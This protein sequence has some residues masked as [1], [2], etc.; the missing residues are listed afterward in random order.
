MAFRR[1][2]PNRIS[3][4]SSSDREL[5]LEQVN[6]ALRDELS[7]EVSI[8]KSNEKYIKDLER[9]YTRC[10]NE[11]Q[12]LNKELEQLENASN[13]EK[14]ELR[15]EISSLK[16][17]L[18]QAKKEVR[19][20]ISY[21]DNIEKQLQESE[22]RIQN[23]RHRFK[24][25]SSRR[26]S[27]SLYNSEEEDIDME[28]LDLFIQIE[29]GLTRIEN[30]LRGAGTPLNNPINIIN[31]IRGSLNTVRHN[32]QSAYQDIDGVIAQRDDSN[33]QIVQLQQDVNYY[34]QQN[35][36]LQN[37]TNQLIQV[38]DTLQ[39][40]VNRLTLERNNSQNNLALMTTAYN[41]ERTECRRWR[42]IAQ[43]FE[44]GMQMR[45]NNLLL[46]KF[47]LNF[48]LRRCQRHG[49]EL[50]QKYDMRGY[51]WHNVTLVL[52][53][54]FKLRHAFEIIFKAFIYRLEQE[55]Q[56]CRGDKGLLE[57]NRDRLF[58][59][60]YNKFKDRKASHIKWKNR[61]RN[62]QQL[63]LNLQAQI[64][65]LQN[66]Q[67]INLNMAAADRQHIYQTIQTSLAHIPSYIGQEP[68]DDYSVNIQNKSHSD[69][70]D[71][72]RAEID[73]IKSQLALIPTTLPQSTQP[74]SQRQ[75]GQL[76]RPSQMEPGKKYRDPD[77]R[78]NDQEW[79][80]M[81]EATDRLSALAGPSTL[82]SLMD[83]I[84]KG[85]MD[86]ITP[87]LPNKKKNTSND[88]MDEI[89]K[90]MAELSINKAIAKGIEA[91]VNAVI[92]SSKHRCSNCNRTGHNSRKCTRKK[93]SKSRS[94]KRGSVNKVAVDSGS[95][96]NSSDNDSSDN[97]SDSGGS[98]SEVESDHSFDSSSKKR[99]SLES[100]IQRS[101]QKM[102]KKS[103]M[104]IDSQIRKIIL[105]MFNDPEVIETIK[106]NIN[107][108]NLSIAKPDFINYR[109]PAPEIPESDDEEETLNDPME[110]D[111]VRRKEPATSLATIPCKIKR[112]KIPALVLDSGAEPPITSEDIVKRV[113]WPIDK[114]E[115]YD[116][117]GVATV[118][119]ESIGIARNF[120][121]TFPP[122][123]TIREDFVVVR[124][125]KPT[126]IFPN[127][128]LKK[129]KCAIDWGKDELKIPFNGKDHIIPVTMHKV[130]NKL[131]VNC[132]T[133]S[134]DDKPLVSDQLS[135]E[136][137]SDK[138][139]NVPLE[140]WHAPVGFSS[141]S[142]NS[143][144]KK[145]A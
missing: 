47:T 49:R 123:F 108:T 29:R 58:D 105:A 111:F 46:E 82:Q 8:N 141:D 96:T 131:E 24:V 122:G 70:S 112:L 109:E 59:R 75:E 18:Y 19:D 53:E 135:Q 76:L 32:Y 4:G 110:I 91:G 21:I 85:V 25:I 121:I 83:T 68:P 30:H 119:T 7:N 78:L 81:D 106:N 1:P 87:F 84:S 38:R 5:E 3:H 139:N 130:K 97:N 67:P 140:E 95:D 48:K 74:T 60:Y 63:I 42:G 41:N 13:E 52:E 23:L 17:S 129:Y 145:N 34:R 104:I 64:L 114:S 142:N 57:Y 94:K 45:I 77:L 103:G 86:R 102:Q 93:R 69:S 55:L 44:R 138:D 143:T 71:I 36:D 12:S 9:K 26:S 137:D 62:S 133:A 79:L 125:P 43:Q 2:H 128:L 90:G 56:Q 88:D 144:L 54:Q 73:M 37:Q 39:N 40:H 11:I 61:E 113:N 33:N 72:T 31:G 16:R 100:P 115:K 6:Q 126:L 50:Q 35:A 107:N 10:E 22:E 65:L 98:S 92:K 15:S 127:P 20:K 134:Q 136:T 14:S 51:L 80:R 101:S 124:V 28:N 27:P 89:T 118:P 99:Q 116:L 117:S 120:P 66:N 132:A